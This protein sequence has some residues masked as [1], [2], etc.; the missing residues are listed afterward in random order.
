MECLDERL[1]SGEAML[2]CPLCR[3]DPASL[4]SDGRAARET[5]D[6]VDYSRTHRRRHAARS[7][8]ALAAALTLSCSPTLDW[9]DVRAAGGLSALFPCKPV[10]L[11][12][13]AVLDGRRVRM[14]L[15][16]CQAG[17][18]SYALTHADVLAPDAV[19][20]ALAALRMALA[21]NVGA[22]ATQEEGA[23]FRVPGTTPG[24]QA[25][26]LRVPGRLPDG[27]VVEAH[28]AFFAAGTHVYQSVVLGAH[29]Q[30]EA[31]ETFFGALKLP[32]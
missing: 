2:R 26:R 13:D 15:L 25:L 28:A 11:A 16:S 24:P 19:A 8:T 4:G 18:A 30:A 32:A 22:A 6:R 27:S 20:P 12:R 21:A 9:R 5:I 14:T 3:V 10:A 29:P 1:A 31:V 17:G 23:P 7:A